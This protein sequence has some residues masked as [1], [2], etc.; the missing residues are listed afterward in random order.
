MTPK[1]ALVSILPALV[2]VLTVAMGTGCV[3]LGALTLEAA[4]DVGA[5]AVKAAYQRVGEAFV[6]V[7]AFFA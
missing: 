6:V 2:D 3:A 5:G 7:D 1:C 4:F